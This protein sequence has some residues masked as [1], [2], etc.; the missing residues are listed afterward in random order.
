MVESKGVQGHAI[1]EEASIWNASGDISIKKLLSVFVT[2][3]EPAVF[4]AC[5]TVSQ[6]F[7]FPFPLLICTTLTNPEHLEPP[8]V[9]CEP[10]L[11]GN[12]TIITPVKLRRRDERTETSSFFLCQNT[13][14]W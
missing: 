12:C 13:H 14:F 9:Y 7:C 3:L 1:R 11:N 4:F 2:P 6:E 8:T 10:H 5:L